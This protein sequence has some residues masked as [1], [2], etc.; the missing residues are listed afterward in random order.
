[1]YQS[2][3]ERPIHSDG[4]HPHNHKTCNITEKDT[5]F[6]RVGTRKEVPAEVGRE[7]LA[8]SPPSHPQS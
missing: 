4:F 8:Q 3:K 5:N 2:S 7:G 1:M 6:W